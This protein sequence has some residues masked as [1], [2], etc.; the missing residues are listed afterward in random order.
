MLNF[1]GSHF[2]NNEI[3]STTL[4][5]RQPSPGLPGCGIRTRQPSKFWLPDLYHRNQFDNPTTLA[6]IECKSAHHP[7]KYYIIYII[8]GGFVQKAHQAHPPDSS[9]FIQG[10]FVQKAHQ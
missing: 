2:Y 3:N 4:A 10:G 1:I 6:R 8:Q 9:K 7:S 5:I